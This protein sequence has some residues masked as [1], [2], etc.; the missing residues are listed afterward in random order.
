MVDIYSI[1]LSA[2]VLVT[3]SSGVLNTALSF[4]PRYPT[5][6]LLCICTL[7]KYVA[8][9]RLCN[10]VHSSSA[11]VPHE[12]AIPALSEPPDGLLKPLSRCVPFYFIR[13]SLAWP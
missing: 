13:T 6:E 5:I 7:L 9:Y 3:A 11:F 12:T 1:H 10:L 8:V 2:A 4:Q